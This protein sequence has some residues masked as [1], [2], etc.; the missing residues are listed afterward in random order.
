MIFADTSGLYALLDKIDRNHDAANRL[1]RSFA[2]RNETILTSSYVLVES[3]ALIQARLGMA[4]LLDFYD[5]TIPL[6]TVRWIDKDT[7]EDALK[8]LLKLNRR[9]VSLVDCT[10]F[11]LMRNNNLQ[12]AFAFDPHFA[13]QGFKQ[14]SIQ[15]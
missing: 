10:S 1:W 4:A 8:T 13:E 11:V 15:E 6:L 12:E 3:H 9:K 7:H 14:A 2:R 5:R